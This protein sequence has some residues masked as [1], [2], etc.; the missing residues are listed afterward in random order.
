MSKHANKPSNNKQSLFV[1]LCH[2]LASKCVRTHFL[3]ELPKQWHRAVKRDSQPGMAQV[4]AGPYAQF[5][6]NVLG[7]NLTDFAHT[8]STSLKLKEALKNISSIGLG[9]LC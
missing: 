9:P 1:V 3:F 7:L 2:L 4:L 5:L 8:I 6:H